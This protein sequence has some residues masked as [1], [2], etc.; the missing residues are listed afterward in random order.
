MSEI[1]FLGIIILGVPFAYY[2]VKFCVWLGE[3]KEK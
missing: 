1:Q 2:V 3:R